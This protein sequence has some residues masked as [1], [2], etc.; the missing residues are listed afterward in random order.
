MKGHN[1]SGDY[2]ARIKNPWNFTSAML[3]CIF[4]HGGT[5]IRIPCPSGG[6]GARRSGKEVT[7]QIPRRMT[8]DRARSY[9]IGEKQSNGIERLTAAPRFEVHCWILLW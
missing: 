2:V 7:H 5:G 3:S 9:A 6:E 4:R 8:N 1:D